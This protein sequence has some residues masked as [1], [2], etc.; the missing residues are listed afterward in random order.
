MRLDEETLIEI[1]DYIEHLSET[2]G[3]SPDTVLDVKRAIEKYKRDNSKNST[4]MVKITSYPPLDTWAFYCYGQEFEVIDRGTHYVLVED[5][6]KE[7]QARCLPKE[8]VTV[9]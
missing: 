7:Y 9:I 6:D 1:D 5:K 2:V 4:I 3:L 8:F